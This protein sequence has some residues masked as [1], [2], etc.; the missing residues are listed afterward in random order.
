MLRSH[1]SHRCPC[2]AA[3]NSARGANLVSKQYKTRPT[4]PPVDAFQSSTKLVLLD[5][6]C[7][8]QS[9]TKLVRPVATWTRF[10][11]VQNSSHSMRHAHVSKQ[12]KTRPARH[13]MHTLQSS[14]NLI[15]LQ[16]ARKRFKAVQ[17]SLDLLHRGLVSKQYKTRPDPPALV[18]MGFE[19]V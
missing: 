16:H 8:Y 18:S 14:T 6:P 2:Q 5:A 15:P 10:K 19:V 9:S 1:L 7:T 4:R 13:S 17:N 3:Q 11:A 12:Y